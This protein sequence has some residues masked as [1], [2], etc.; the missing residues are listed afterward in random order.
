MFVVFMLFVV[1][2]HPLTSEDD[3]ELSFF[4]FLQVGE[5]WVGGRSRD[6]TSRLL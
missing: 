4:F 2:N 3:G 5:V 1:V 6:V